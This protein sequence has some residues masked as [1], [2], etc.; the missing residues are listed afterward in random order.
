VTGRRRTLLGVW[1]HPDDEA[2]LPAGLV[3]R[4]LDEGWRVGV[5]TAGRGE[6]GTDDPGAALPDR[7]AAVRAAEPEHAALVTPRSQT[8]GRIAQLG[9]ARYREWWATEAFVTARPVALRAAA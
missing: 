4:A 9:E 7:L 1:A 2:I 5:A 3:A 8:A 6:V